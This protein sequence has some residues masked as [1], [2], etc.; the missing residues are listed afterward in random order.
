M[1]APSPTKPLASRDVNTSLPSPVKDSTNM[2]EKEITSKPKNMD[3]HRQVLQS[4][5][6]EDKSKQTYISPSDNIMSPCTKKLSEYKS[7]HFMKYVSPD[8]PSS[9]FPVVSPSDV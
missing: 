3:Y 7:K 1:S 8:F 9:A 6:A 5:L 4:R 2:P